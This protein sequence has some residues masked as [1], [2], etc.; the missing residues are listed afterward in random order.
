M[1]SQRRCATKRTDTMEGN[2][3]RLYQGGYEPLGRSGWPMQTN[4]ERAAL[5][6]YRCG[7]GKLPRGRAW[8]RD[9][10]ATEKEAG[11]NLR[12]NSPLARN[13]L[14]H[15]EMS[16]GV[17]GPANEPQGYRGWLHF[18]TSPKDDMGYLRLP[19]IRSGYRE[20]RE[21]LRNRC[22]HHLVERISV[23]VGGSHMEMSSPSM[24]YASVGGSIVV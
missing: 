4:R 1:V 23:N 15:P 5:K 20:E 10:M 19:H 2:S 6:R 7:R 16:T 13:I 14:P 3:R 18:V 17:Y 8:L 12:E 24:K 9:G 21:W 22:L 11:F